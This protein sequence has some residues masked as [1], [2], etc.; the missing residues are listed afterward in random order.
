METV[1]QAQRLDQ[2]K[3][4]QEKKEEAR[5]EKKP[6]I[7]H[8]NR[9]LQLSLIGAF[10]VELEGSSDLADKP[11]HLHGIPGTITVLK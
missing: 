4:L 10:P 2:S 7:P 6:T 5:K 8:H 9:G 3:F 11:P 1:I